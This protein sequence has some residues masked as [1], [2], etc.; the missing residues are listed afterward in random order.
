MTLFAHV[1]AIA[2]KVFLNPAAKIINA[3]GGAVFELQGQGPAAFCRKYYPAGVEIFDKNLASQ[4][5]LIA[6]AP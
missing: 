4:T 2:I 1:S 5:A 3:D 6:G